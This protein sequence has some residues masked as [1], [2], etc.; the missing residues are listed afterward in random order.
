MTVRQQTSTAFT[1]NGVAAERQEGSPP[2]ESSTTANSATAQKSMA[3]PLAL[4]REN[5]R[6]VSQSRGSSL[7]SAMQVLCEVRLSTAMRVPA[8]LQFS[9]CCI[10]VVRTRP[11]VPGGVSTRFGASAP[12]GG[13]RSVLASG[14]TWGMGDMPPCP[15]SPAAGPIAA[16][17]VGKAPCRALG[18]GAIGGCGAWAMSDPW[19]WKQ[20]SASEIRALGFCFG[21]LPR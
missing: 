12:S 7:A 10:A 14:E 13:T 4:P 16:P 1:G 15:L 8:E 5:S 20:L 3:L 19:G 21:L 17:G 6:E 2:S 11:S 18:L 9:A